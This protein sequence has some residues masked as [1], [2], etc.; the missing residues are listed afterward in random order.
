MK[1]EDMIVLGAVAVGGYYAYSKGW[2][3]GLFGSAAAAPTGGKTVFNAAGQLTT[4]ATQYTTP[5]QTITNANPTTNPAVAVAAPSYTLGD[6][7]TALGN[8][9]ADIGQ[10]FTP[11][12]WNSALVTVSNGNVVPPDP[13][14]VWPGGNSGEQ[15]RLDT[16]WQGMAPWLQTNKG[17]S[18]IRGISI[19]G[20]RG[21]WFA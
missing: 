20:L 17:L 10:S 11:L 5:S 9:T 8:Y 18:G 21:G 13:S 16:Y 6:L 1:T 14:A 2:F 4:L 7:Y 15:M 19:R 12:Q 3:S